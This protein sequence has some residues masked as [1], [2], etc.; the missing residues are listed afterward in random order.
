MQ[1]PPNQT[2]KKRP[3]HDVRNILITVKKKR[4]K[5][6]TKRHYELQDYTQPTVIYHLSN[7]GSSKSRR[8][9]TK[10]VSLPEINKNNANEKTTKLKLKSLTTIHREIGKP[11]SKKYIL[12]EH[13]LRFN[14][15]PLS[16]IKQPTFKVYRCQLTPNV[17]ENCNN[18][19]CSCNSD[20][21]FEVMK[22]LYDCYK[23]RNCDNC[24]CILCC[25]LPTEKQL[26]KLGKPSPEINL[27]TALKEVAMRGFALP[28][29]KTPSE[30]IIINNIRRRLGLPP[31]PTSRHMRDKYTNAANVGVM[32]PL[33]GKTIK[34]KE[35]IL[36]EFHRLGI[37]PPIGRTFS[38]Q[39]LIDK[40][41]EKAQARTVMC[42]CQS[43]LSESSRKTKRSDLLTTWQGKTNDEI[44]KIL[45]EQAMKGIPLPKGETESKAKLISKVRADLGLPPSPRTSDL[46]NKYANAAKD[47]I[48]F[49]LEGKSDKEKERILRGLHE[50]GLPLPEGRTSSEKAM[51][52]K[53]LQEKRS[54]SSKI[55]K[56]KTEQEKKLRELAMNGILL[57]EAKTESDKKIFKKVRADL[58]L[59][60]DPK[61]QDMR[62]KYDKAANIGLMLPLEGKSLKEKEKILRGLAELGIP[63]PKGRTPSEVALIAKVKGEPRDSSMLTQLK[64]KDVDSSKVIL[65]LEGKTPEEIEKI[66]RKLAMRGVPLPE[67]KTASQK[68]LINKVRVELGLPPDP[69]T[70]AMKKKHQIAAEE[71]LLLPLAGKSN[72]EKEIIIQ[73]L[74]NIGISLPKG[75]TASEKAL[76]VRV[77]E[78]Q[79]ND[80]NT[81]SNIKESEGPVDEC[82]CS[83]LAPPI[84][85]SL[86]LKRRAKAAEQYLEGKTSDEKSKILLSLAMEGIPLPKGK[87]ASEKKLI[88]KIRADLGLPPEPKTASIRDKHVKAAEKN[89]LQPLKGKSPQEKERILRGLLDIGIQLPEPRTASEKSMIVRLQL[90][91]KTPSGKMKRAKAAGLLTPLEGKIPSQQEDILRGLAIIGIPLPK[92]KTDSQTKLVIKIRNDLGLPPEPKNSSMRN[93]YAKA[94]D[95]GL[96]VPLEGKSPKEKEKILRGLNDLGIPL[97]KA[98]SP[99]EEFLII[100][101]Q[102]KRP[103]LTPSEKMRGAKAAGLLTPLR[104]KTPAQRERILRGLAVHGISLPQGE[105]MSEKKL[106][107]KVR[108]DLGLPPEP[109]TLSMREKY[110]KAVDAGILQPLE[111]KTPREKEK[112]LRRLVEVGIPLPKART[113]SEKAL[114]DK[115]KGEPRT[116]SR[117]TPSEKMR[118]A[119]STGLLTPLNGKTPAEIQVILKGL[120]DLGIPLPEGKSASE[121]NIINKV[122]LDLG[123]PPEPKTSAMREKHKKAAEDGLLIPL[124]GKLPKEKKKILQGLADMG[125]PLPVGRTDS[126]KSLVAKINERK[127]VDRKSSQRPRTSITTEKIRQAKAAGLLTPLAKKSPEEKENILRNLFKLGL[128]LPEGRTRSDRA[129][130]NQIKREYNL[131]EEP[132]GEKIRKA[133]ANGLLT[134]LDGKTPELKEKIL[135][136]RVAA[137]FPLPVGKTLSEKD[138][139]S[140]VK[141]STGYVTPSPSKMLQK[142]EA[143]SLLPLKGGKTA[144]ERENRLRQLTAAGIPLPEGKTP[145]EKE[146]INKIKALH[147]TKSDKIKAA[148]AAGLLTPLRG[149]TPE[150]KEKI[151]RGLVKNSLPL[152]EAKTPSEKSLIDKIRAETGLPPTP[153]TP[154]MKEKYRRAQ[155]AGIITPLEGKSMSKKEN[156]LRKLH[157]E[158]ISLPAGRTPSEKLLIKRIKSGLLGHK[159]PFDDMEP[160]K[161]EKILRNLIKSGRSLSDAK[162]PSAIN[163]IKQV[164]KDMGLPPEPTTTSMKDKMRKAYSAGLITPLEGKTSAQKEKILRGL[165]EAGIPLPEGRTSSE[166][167]MKRKIEDESR[168]KLHKQATKRITKDRGVS[169]ESGEAWPKIQSSKIRKAEELGLATPLSGKSPEEKEKI[170]RGLAKL[171]LPLPEGVTKSDKQLIKRVRK[172]MGLPPDPETPSMKKRHFKAAKE[173]VLYPLEGL[174]QAEKENLLRSQGK[175]GLTLPEGRTPSDKSLINKIKEELALLKIV[176]EKL[177]R[178]K[179]AGLHTPLKGKSQAEKEKI[180]RGRAKAGLPLPEGRTMSEKSLIKNIKSELRKPRMST[181]ALRKT[182]ER[183]LLTPLDGK[184]SSEKEKILHG[185]AEAG[186]PFPEGKTSKD[187]A[188]MKKVKEAHKVV[189]EKGSE[190]KVLGSTVTKCERACGCDKKKIRFKHSYVK[191]K[192]TSPDISS[193]CPCPDECVP[194]VKG[195]VFIDNQGVNVIIESAVGIPHYKVSSNALSENSQRDPRQIYN[196]KRRPIVSDIEHK[197]RNLIR[198]IYDDNTVSYRHI[199]SRSQ[200]SLLD[201]QFSHIPLINERYNKTYR[202]APKSLQ[203]SCSKICSTGKIKENKGHG[204]KSNLY[205]EAADFTTYVSNHLTVTTSSSQNSYDSIKIIQSETSLSFSSTYDEVGSSSVISFAASVSSSKSNTCQL[206]F[207][208]VVFNGSV[209]LGSECPTNGVECCAI[210]SIRRYLI[211]L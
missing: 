206:S 210:D 62:N 27:E 209:V 139:I 80:K 186:L 147:K 174:T 66:L 41:G 32:V 84:L 99:S 25:R 152:P 182:K 76:I 123:L 116:L 69:K 158:G 140:K 18:C 178:A 185:L 107:N 194:G 162:T 184:T 53:I 197:N 189:K 86:D 165:A 128:P 6:R 9:I 179:E 135:R 181:E 133:I 21:M 149:K 202:Q 14:L 15:N 126:E 50:R 102:G 51:V 156:I 89:L 148:K 10:H 104:S 119:K 19:C 30:K 110:D 193:L 26:D 131:H 115:I 151:L 153:K 4:N 137:G 120:A 34:Q 55:S 145:S 49:P 17:A 142:A 12:K 60:P 64:M 203:S 113:A 13:S 96:L 205:Y 28:E 121:Q 39:A 57:P 52:G 187:R 59:P 190:T 67:G 106:I 208:N 100:K 85:I 29:G 170:L 169:Q 81:S 192:V 42:E 109:K 68:K 35:K 180:L 95:A 101:I 97:P 196:L 63:L 138:L 1:Y 160:A 164:R 2:N 157:E 134:P 43:K 163:L 16:K 188:L 87:T 82:I 8:F 47:G 155:D 54:S 124:E 88:S 112:I 166:K 177:Q 159:T 118:K 71:G 56:T 36:R 132:S 171:G 129:L 195:G 31:E 93:K 77:K 48:L 103:T 127:K 122:R 75:R 176:P 141:A 91:H 33:E 72:E 114:I 24:N 183:G 5:E 79:K 22:D 83:K 40:I 207:S 130:I 73:G 204:L 172:D 144:S 3:S 38:E 23:K 92:G 154:S 11:Y 94:A 108:F 44:E 198:S 46:R 98:R 65:S 78:R 191:I 70:P 58:G 37:P 150:Q 199:Y 143:A 90:E 20:A 168:K 74:L 136:R 211:V 7:F 173:G 167:E 61:T 45:R 146:I 175:I 161:K 111:G 117:L 125:I 201:T 200:D 105:T